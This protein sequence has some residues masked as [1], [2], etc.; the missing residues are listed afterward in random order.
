MLT[1]L[2]KSRFKL[3]LE[4][5]TRVFFSAN[6]ELYA[7]TL[8]DDEFLKMLAYG[9]NQVGALAKLMFL[10]EDPTAVEVT[11]RVHEQQVVRTQRL[12]EQASA[13]VFEGTLQYGS[14]VLRADVLRK[15]DNVLDL[16][17]VKATGWDARN[18]SLTGQTERS[19]PLSPA[20][21]SYVYDL[22][23]QHHVAALVYPDL[24]INPWLL[25]LDTHCSVAI[26]GLAKAFVTT[27]HGGR[28]SVEI[29]PDF[30][31]EQL[32]RIPLV[33]VDAKEA[34]AIAQSTVRERRGKDPIVFGE[35]VQQLSDALERKEKIQVAPN[36]A[37]K[38]CPFYLEPGSE[39]P[40]K[41]GWHE[42]MGAYFGNSTG[43]SRKS[44]V[45]G[46]YRQIRYDDILGARQLSMSKLAD[47][48]T[49]ERIDFEA[50]KIPLKFRQH[51]QLEESKGV[52][53]DLVFD[54]RAVREII[55]QWTFPLHFI[56]FET[57]R[58]ALP[59]FKGHRPYQQVLFQFSHHV[60]N[61]EG[62]IEHRSEC[63]IA[64]P[65]RNPSIE[66]LRALK[67][68]LENDQ[69][70]VFHWY[71]HERTVLQEIREEMD[72]DPPADMEDVRSFLESLG[73]RSGGSGRMFDLGRF[74]EQYIF[75]PGSYGSSSMKRVLPA[76]FRQSAHIKTFYG[77]PVYGTDQM[78]SKNFKDKAWYVEKEGT[79]INPYEQLGSRFA[80]GWIENR[81]KAIEDQEGEVHDTGVADGAAA[82]LAF[83]K[84][85]SYQTSVDEREMLTA[86]LKRYCELDTLAMVMAYQA[87]QAHIKG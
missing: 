19:N 26:D 16:I 7:N 31:W 37:C 45:F 46:F 13:T 20:F 66:V 39:S 21:E 2:T 83:D 9:G 22:A 4:C 59:Y 41:S 85:Q 62:A 35:A 54:G 10:R 72:R 47:I 8:S 12:L 75:I 79:V 14:L 86:Q 38:S 74:F 5:P 1:T 27:E 58:V 32:S 17:E 80:E 51:L 64:E 87:I 18:D 36:S 49:S 71:P 68:A 11:D 70:T 60:V 63:L 29:S 24:Q 76:L 34:V 30:D 50:G 53:K 3:G 77:R 78:P 44:S 48:G 84:L 69:G 65:G 52:V 25:L 56:D 6:R 55:D 23:F 33:M 28:S 82:I 40:L 81:L 15:R 73:L 43:I 57:S 42:C 67:E 61:Q